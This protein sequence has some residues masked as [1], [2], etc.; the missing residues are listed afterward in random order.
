[1]DEDMRYIDPAAYAELAADAD[2]EDFGCWED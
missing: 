2:C 1:M